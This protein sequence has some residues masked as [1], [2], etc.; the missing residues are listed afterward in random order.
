[1]S[2]NQEASNAA[3][4]RQKIASVR[5]GLEQLESRLVPAKVVTTLLDTT[6]A[7]T[8]TPGSL[9]AAVTSN[10]PSDFIV[11]F[12]DYL[13]ASSI[14]VTH[15]P[16]ALALGN[17]R[18]AGK[19]D[20]VSASRFTSSLSF[21][22]DDN[23]GLG[24]LSQ[25]STTYSASFTTSNIQAL[26]AVELNSDGK[27]DIITLGADGNIRAYLGN[28]NGTF[29][30]PATV[31]VGASAAIALGDFN[32]DG[33]T[34]FAA[35]LTGSTGKV[36]FALGNGD[37]TFQASQTITL[38]G[39]G[40][41]N[42]VSLAVGDVTGDGIDDVVSLSSAGVLTTLPGDLTAPLST[43]VA[44]TVPGSPFTFLALGDLD[45]D[46]RA[47]AV[48]V[49]SASGILTTVKAST[50]T[51]GAFLVTGT[52]LSTATLATGAS[53]GIVRVADLNADGK[54][55]LAVTQYGLDNVAI[56]TG[57]GDGTLNSGPSTFD[58]VDPT[59]IRVRDMNADGLPDIVASSETSQ[60]FAVF[61]NSGS[62]SF[63]PVAKKQATFILNGAVGA[64]SDTLNNNLT[65]TGGAQ[66]GPGDFDA[67]GN[68]LANLP[69][70]IIQADAGFNLAD[71]D[72]TRTTPLL[73]GS[74]YFD[75]AVVNR[76][77]GFKV[78]DIIQQGIT[79][80]QGGARFQVTGVDAA[81]GVTTIRVI[82]PG[83][84]TVY[85]PF[86]ATNT[87][88]DSRL[89]QSGTTLSQSNTDPYF[90]L[91]P[92][93]GT[94]TGLVIPTYYLNNV[95][96][97]YQRLL[98]VS[99][100]SSGLFFQN[101]PSS[102]SLTLDGLSLRASLDNTITVTQGSLTVTNSTFDDLDTQF[103]TNRGN[104]H[105]INLQT[106]AGSLTVTNTRFENGRLDAINGGSS[107]TIAITG[108]SF[109]NNDGQALRISAGT[110]TI[111]GTTFTNNGDLESNIS[112]EIYLLG[113]TISSTPPASPPLGI[114]GF[115]GGRG[116][117]A[118]GTVTATNITVSNSLFDNNRH[119]TIPSVDRALYLNGG[120]INVSN[121][122]FRNHTNNGALELTGT[123]ATV[124]T[125]QFEENASPLT[126]NRE[127]PTPTLAQGDRLRGGA[128][129]LIRD[130]T[131]LTLSLSR[132]YNN[133]VD[134]I[135]SRFSGGGAIYL[136]SGTATIAECAFENNTA[137]ITDYPNSGTPG[138]GNPETSPTARYSGG[139][140]L[141][142]GG[143]TV[144]RDSYFT[145]NSV[146]SYV[147]IW[148]PSYDDTAAPGRPQYSGG[149][150][151]LLTRN[152]DSAIT[153]DVFNTTFVGNFVQ[154]MEANKDINGAGKQRLDSGIAYIPL[155]AAS[156][157]RNTGA[158]SVGINDG[159]TNKGQVVD[160][161]D[162]VIETV[163]T[164]DA[165]NNNTVV[166]SSLAIGGSTAQGNTG[167]SVANL[168]ITDNQLSATTGQDIP[169]PAA[170]GRTASYQL[171]GRYVAASTN[172]TAPTGTPA[173]TVIF[174]S[175]TTPWFQ[176]GTPMTG[177]I[178]STAYTTV[179][180][181]TSA[182][183][184]NAY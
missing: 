17:F 42:L 170:S 105:F 96:G 177:D 134:N 114:G 110:V 144:I 3:K 15:N 159:G 109:S 85:D 43:K 65:I 76:G 164:T 83:S 106:G 117:N 161:S 57:K 45:G 12:N 19:N 2:R 137:I 23:R 184:A 126:F 162:A 127:W 174:P 145:N 182:S 120:T 34:D 7:S 149:G 100:R 24:F 115:N 31:A 169:T 152:V 48:A 176:S 166:T 55:D 56:Y 59:D 167:T 140:A 78:G 128:A 63:N 171:S 89:G 156:V 36:M 67:A 121:S 181:I 26:E 130:A 53:P 28:G 183:T 68:S 92:S 101:T 40:S 46:S 66:F 172:M 138:F 71:Y 52:G 104:R 73:P 64:I 86:S 75:P 123:K 82:Q 39:T 179:T 135:D 41:G 49:N 103:G 151:V 5:P 124:T 69:R 157:S 143:A 18:G 108:S 102:R 95:T 79:N 91:T 50:A 133:K 147:D 11:A 148:N 97:T 99:D 60:S 154:Q 47:D 163:L 8:P 38:S 141:Y 88:I 51:P 74:T 131:P 77:S 113:Q 155:D 25:A 62:A 37:G 54:A 146:L 142:A 72:L 6:N 129:I 173:T 32:K 122:I 93:S 125:S 9:R 16:T 119:A 178:Y 116:M 27:T 158:Q 98:A 35:A 44:T 70:A 175:L 4:R 94:G 87:R 14:G 153:S 107:G 111:T 1:M 22:P 58:V 81:G 30:A 136:S 118:A 150:A 21:S 139:G 20:V 112:K 168:R 33:K 132:F 84:Q 165:G 90:R 13:F 61:T 29:G 10:V 180:T 160:G 80:R